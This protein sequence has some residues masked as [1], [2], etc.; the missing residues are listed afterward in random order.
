MVNRQVALLAALILAFDPFILAHSRIIHV[1]AP[2]SYFMFLSFLAFLVYLKEGAW[3]WLLLSGL[4]GGLAGL[5]KTPAAILGPILVVSGVFYALFPPP[6]HTRSKMWKRLVIALIV[7]GLIAVAAIFILWPSMWSRPLDAI[8]RVTTNITSVNS[9]AHPTTGIFWGGQQSDQN[10]LY[11]LIVFPYHLTPL[12]TAGVISGLAMIVAGF[13][14]W[15]KPVKNWAAPDATTDV[16]VSCLRN[17][18]YGPCVCYCPPGRSVTVLPVYFAVGLFSAISLLWLATLLAKYLP[19]AMSRLKLTPARLV[20]MLVLLQALFVLLYHPY[21]LAYFN[22]LMGSYRTAP[23][24]L[25][26]GWGEGLDVAARYLNEQEIKQDPLTVA[27]WYSNQFA[28]YYN[29][30]TIDLSNQ[31]AAPNRRPHRFLH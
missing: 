18:L 4:F 23:Y 17:Y 2:M 3:K 13:V 25:N 28:P 30:Q 19:V 6:E 31:E 8:Y 24:Q 12:T 20:G 10:P 26:V 1:D 16:G 11:Y 5:S 21:Y 7:W 22:P 27:S 14:N 9:R 29:G 15:R